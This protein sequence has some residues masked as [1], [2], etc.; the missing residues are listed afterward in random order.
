MGHVPTERSFPGVGT[1]I[2][3]ISI[4]QSRV[5]QLLCLQGRQRNI[6]KNVS[7]NI[8]RFY[9]KKAQ[10]ILGRPSAEGF[11]T[12]SRNLFSSLPYVIIN[13]TSTDIEKTLTL[14]ISNLHHFH[15]CF[16]ILLLRWLPSWIDS[17]W[18]CSVSMIKH[19]RLFIYS[20]R[21]D[22][23]EIEYLLLGTNKTSTFGF[24]VPTIMEKQHG[25]SLSQ[26]NMMSDVIE[27]NARNCRSREKTM[28][29]SIWE[30]VRRR[31]RRSNV[32]SLVHY[33]EFLRLTQR[34]KVIH[35]L[36]L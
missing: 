13:Q 3:L 5:A 36:F 31:H 34:R 7:L 24:R 29:N 4:N 30:W 9:W 8:L 6:V 15:S 2:L 12:V 32:S 21:K 23:W 10:K 1:M 14:L 25:T 33:S 28:M 18:P 20:A 19:F 27:T 17:I 35:F 11:C 16:I 26:C 22:C